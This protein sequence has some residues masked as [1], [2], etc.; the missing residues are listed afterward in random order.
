MLEITGDEITALNDSDLRVLV[1][2]LCEAELHTQNLSTAGVTF[3]GHQDAPDGGLDV[4]VQVS[5]VPHQGGFI[6]K[7]DT[8]FQIKKPDMPRAEIIKEMKPKGELRQVIKELV[9][10]NGAYIIISSTGSTT[11]SALTNRREAMREALGKDDSSHQVTIDFYDRE[12]VA[13]WVR[14]HPS[15]GLWVREKIGKAMLGWRAFGNWANPL[16]DITEEFLL[17]GKVRFYKGEINP[18]NAMPLVEGINSLRKVLRQPRSSVRLIGL[19]G[20]GKTRLVQALFDERIGIKHLNPSQVFYTDMSNMPN[21]DPPHFAEHLIALKRPAILVID[22]CPP[23]LHRQLTSVCGASGSLVS[24]ITIEYDIR[25]DQPEETK[26]YRLEPASEG[27]IQKLLQRRFPSLS[28]I[29]AQTIARFSGGNSRI[30]LAVADTVSQ[31]ETPARLRDDEL[32]RRLFEQ[33]NVP[34]SNLLKSAE[35]CSLVYSFDGEN[36][37][38]LSELRLLG[39]LA[40]MSAKELFSDVAELKRRGLV[41]QRNVW[42]AVLPPAI[43]NRLA[44]RA[45]ENLPP[46]DI[47]K[48]FEGGPERFLQ[49]FSR[50]LSYLHESPIGVSIATIWLAKD[51]P[52]EDIRKISRHK[53]EL[54]TNIAP[55]V[56][57]LVVKAIEKALG[58]DGSK[59]FCCTN[60]HLKYLAQILRSIAYD[61]DLFPR[62]A[63]LLSKFALSEHPD[64][65]QIHSRDLLKSLFSIEL[66]GTHA[67]ANQRL[68]IIKGLFDSQEEEQDELGLQL[69]SAALNFSHYSNHYHFDFGGHSRDYGYRPKNEKEIQ[70]WFNLFI[71]FAMELALSEKPIAMKAKS[72]LASMSRGL[73]VH[74]GMFDLLEEVAIA[75]NERENWHE[76]WVEIGKTIIFDASHL[77]C[78]LVER[79]KT[80][81][82][83]LTPSNL[84]EKGRTCLFVTNDPFPNF[85]VI[86]QEIPKSL[87]AQRLQNEFDVKQ[88]GK[89]VAENPAVFNLLLP[90]MFKAKGSRHFEFGQGLAQGCNDHQGMWDILKN[91][92][93]L[94]SSEERFS[95][96]LRGFLSVTSQNN[97]KI[98][99]EILDKAV[100]DEILAP[101]YPWLQ[102]MIKIKKQGVKRLKQSLQHGTAPISLYQLLGVGRV[103]ETIDNKSFCDLLRIIKS[104]PDGLWVAIE[105]FCM[106]LHKKFRKKSLKNLL[107]ISLGG[108]LLTQ[109]QFNQASPKN[110]S[111]DYKLNLIADACLEG[112]A[113]SATAGSFC[114]KLAKALDDGRLLPLD[115]INL[116]STLA[117][118]QPIIFLDS[119]LSDNSAD[120][121]EM[122]R[123]FSSYIDFEL[124]PLTNI[125][126]NIILDWCKVNPVSRYKIMASVIAPFKKEDVQDKLEWTL[127]ALGLI[128]NAPDPILVLDALKY[129][130]KPMSFSGS[131]TKIMMKRL[132]LFIDLKSNP[133]PVVSE[134]AVREEKWFQGE[135]NSERE[136]EE[137]PNRTMYEGFE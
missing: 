23:D 10:L 50:R 76:G 29:N 88:I 32:F 102:L 8:G 106:R 19:S 134:W 100:T 129:S 44:Q 97:P 46:K 14:F 133:N 6:P 55:I 115:Y 63:L 82:N 4:R 124:N 109:L 125:E 53:V 136:R 83:L 52:L 21:P 131:R 75:I 2:L 25:E 91:Q 65:G 126:D 123:V 45:L 93:S 7:P 101:I 116:L 47:L 74:P 132:S 38:D 13:A 119:F 28:Q 15:L 17:D 98:A 41:Q 58:K 20:V 66:S 77:D 3:G 31:G 30:A 34:Q 12:R 61:P 111:M 57:S 59:L 107:I 112:S 1:G 127:L 35:F 68:E 16:G 90:E 37:D 81:K 92:C 79:L 18:Q 11:D 54:L 39:S 135:I 96:L 72:L 105:I 40:S 64:G 49:S 22:N 62:S 71:R 42:R 51:G 130:L 117:K 5:G 78:Q 108:E 85:D 94:L 95:N 26:V 137:K 122:G 67:T 9:A 56:P 27:L 87:S 89:E 121:Y 86:V 110:S 120:D 84:L 99:E 113:V 48:V 128:E 69:L 103:H 36:T 43:A 80:L 118:K 73:S 114:R 33:R 104:K 70:E 24:L 60:P